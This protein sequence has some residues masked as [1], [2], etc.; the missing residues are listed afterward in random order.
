MH[1]FG[2][3]S[4]I[5]EIVDICNQK[6]ILVIEDYAESMAATLMKNTQVYLGLQVF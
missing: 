3:P 5:E 2:I 6:N 1:T 4:K